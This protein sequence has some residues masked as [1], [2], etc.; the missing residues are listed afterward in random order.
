MVWT[1]KR[2]AALAAIGGIAGPLI[3]IALYMI[4]RETKSVSVE[5][6]SHAT[7]AD[8]TDPALSSLRL[9]FKGMP[10]D[11]VT[12]ATIEIA[13][14][15][16]RPVEPADFERPFVIRFDNT[17]TVLMTA[18]VAEGNPPSL[19]PQ[20]AHDASSVTVSPT[21]LNPGDRFRLTLHLRGVFMEPTV[22]ARIAGIR[23]I[24][25]AVL[26]EDVKRQRRMAVAYLAAVAS[27]AAY[28]YFFPFVYF[29]VVRERRVLVMS[30]TSGV[31]LSAA[32]ALANAVALL[33]VARMWSDPQEVTLSLSRVAA[34][35]VLGLLVGVPVYI[36]G[37]KAAQRA[38]VD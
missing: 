34:V 9:T 33:S 24:S 1:D 35:M 15:G 25:R 11:R 32:L 16:S 7:V 18:A 5:T 38:V 4:A 36:F 19:K 14:T 21:L 17:Y 31:L 29:A 23:D 27:L 22:E 13:N 20:I 8:L 10:V 2:L 12:T 28:F 6:I 37:M 26:R 3:G 30:L